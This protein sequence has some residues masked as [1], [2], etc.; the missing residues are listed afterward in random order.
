MQFLLRNLHRETEGHQV[1]SGQAAAA[2]AARQLD[3]CPVAGL[4]GNGPSVS[5]SVTICITADDGDKI[6]LVLAAAAA[7]NVGIELDEARSPAIIKIVKD[8]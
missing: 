8:T 6:A 3:T 7:I 1:D 5:R 2:T 4:G